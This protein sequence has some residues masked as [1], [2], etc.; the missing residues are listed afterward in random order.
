MK[1][2]AVKK[3]CQHKTEFTDMRDLEKHIRPLQAPLLALARSVR[4]RQHR[5][6]SLGPNLAGVES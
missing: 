2:T 1:V 3:F 5:P 4:P 6:D